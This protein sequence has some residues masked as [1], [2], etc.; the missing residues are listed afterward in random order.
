[1]LPLVQVLL[2]QDDALQAARNGVDA[3]QSASHALDAANAALAGYSPSHPA[4][5]EHAP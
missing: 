3:L 1:M 2:E 5:P 4:A